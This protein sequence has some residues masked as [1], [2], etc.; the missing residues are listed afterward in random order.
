M[1]RWMI[2]QF[3][4]LLENPAMRAAELAQRVGH[5]QGA[6]EAVRG[7]VHGWHSGGNDSGLSREMRAYSEAH[8]T[9]YVCAVCGAT[10]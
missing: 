3:V 6:V 9:V 4:V 2:T 5:S 7:F 8:R 10:M 1:P